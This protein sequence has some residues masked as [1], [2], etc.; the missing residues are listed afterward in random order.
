[1]RPETTA[2]VLLEPGHG[3][4]HP[5]WAMQTMGAGTEIVTRR[6]QGPMWTG[7]LTRSMRLRRRRTGTSLM[8]MERNSGR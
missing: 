7:L 8:F 6:R 1:M 3:P 2:A 5:N 4:P